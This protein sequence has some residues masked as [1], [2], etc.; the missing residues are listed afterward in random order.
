MPKSVKERYTDKS[1]AI[2]CDS[3]IFFEIGSFEITP[4]YLPHDGTENY[5]YY[6]VEKSMGQFVY[7]TD[8][9]YSGMSFKKARIEHLL[10][11]VNY[12]EEL[13]EQE[14]AQYT[15]R[16]RGHLSLNTFIDKVLKV[17]M[18]PALRTVTLCH[19]SDTAADEQMILERVKEV[20]GKRVEVNIAKPGL[21]VCIDK[22]PF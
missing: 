9:E 8:L 3:Y 21:T 2:E 4:F 7:M 1:M 15:H 16:L 13:V 10:C 5:G 6:I 12:C 11:E 17:N 18:T 14:E 19:L 22:F 20:C